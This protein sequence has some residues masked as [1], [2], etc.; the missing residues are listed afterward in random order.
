ML[1]PQYYRVLEKS[2]SGSVYAELSNIGTRGSFYL[3]ILIALLTELAPM[4]RV[5]FIFDI[6]VF[7]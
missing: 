6:I 5:S 7:Y 1:L 3:D 4:K 2:R